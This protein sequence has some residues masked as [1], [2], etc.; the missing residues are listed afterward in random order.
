MV[1]KAGFSIAGFNLSSI[2]SFLSMELHSFTML[3]V[4]CT[5]VLYF[6]SKVDH[7]F[8]YICETESHT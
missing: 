6:H 3:A 7:Y 1:M 4:V 8:H 2:C 5:F